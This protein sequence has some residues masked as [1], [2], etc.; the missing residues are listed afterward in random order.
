LWEELDGPPDPD[1]DAA[2]LEEAR[3]RDKEIE[4]GRVELLPADEVFKRFEASLK[5]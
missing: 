3:R 5:K 4:E 1:V 2:W